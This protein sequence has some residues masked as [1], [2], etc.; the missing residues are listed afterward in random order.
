MNVNEIFYSI[1]GESEWAGYPTVFVRLQ[2][3]NL[4][5]VYCDTDYAQNKKEGNVLT[6]D[7]VAEQIRKYRTG[8][9]CFT[10]GEPL[11]QQ[12]E[13][14]EVI[15]CIPHLR[16][17]NFSIETNGTIKPLSIILNSS[18][19]IV[20]DYKLPSAFS[21][22]EDYD[23]YRRNFFERKLHRCLSGKDEVKFVVD[24]NLADLDEVEEIARGFSRTNIVISP[25]WDKWDLIKLSEWVK[26]HLPQARLQIQMHK[27][28]WDPKT[29]GV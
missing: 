6:S 21:K 1:Q 5:C 15:K 9:I 10:G 24:N 27:I 22:I 29:R 19:K 17:M 3:C 13:I 2:G 25:Q 12:K 18:V 20:M 26:E 23:N 16:N 28:I 14:V 4:K 11:L 8:Y 7:Q